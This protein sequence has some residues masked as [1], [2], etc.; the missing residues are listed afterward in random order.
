MSSIKLTAMKKVLPIL[1]VIEISLVLWLA[2]LYY[3]NLPMNSSYILY[4]PQGSTQQTLSYLKARKFDLTIVDGWALRFLGYPQKGWIH[5]GDTALTHGDFLYRLTTA[6][7]AM[8]SVTL[9]PGE[10]THFFLAHIAQTMQLDHAR[11]TYHFERFAP[12]HEGALVPDTYQLPLGID[13][14]RVM[15]ILLH[16]SDKQMRAWSEKI[17]GTYD[18]KKWFHFVTLASVIQKEAA[19]KEDMP[20]VSSVIYNRLKKGMRLQMDGTLNYGPYSHTPIT[21]ERIKS[22]NT[23]YNTY[24]NA[25][26]P[27]V[28]VCNVGLDAIKAAIFPAQSD[29]LYF[30]RGKEGKHHYSSNYSTHLERINNA[31]K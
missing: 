12:L 17:F 1:S 16:H 4:V 22:D 21:A 20:L 13:E 2:F 29:Y 14:Q 9:I 25:G 6:R 23:S 15:R 30:V 24:I 7:A 19:S 26:L 31:T 11:L 18:A 27:P 8:R 5:I 28:P 10:T 3:L